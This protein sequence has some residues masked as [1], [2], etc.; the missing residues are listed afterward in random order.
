MCNCESDE[1]CERKRH[2]EK[3]EDKKKDREIKGIGITQKTI[4]C[5]GLALT[6]LYDGVARKSQIY[7]GWSLG[8]YTASAD[9]GKAGHA[10]P[11]ERMLPEL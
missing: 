3:S 5:W 10:V 2:E 4:Q 11:C 1:K 7:Y 9:L 8:L 6:I